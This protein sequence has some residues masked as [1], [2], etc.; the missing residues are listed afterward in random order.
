MTE[1]FTTVILDFIGDTFPSTISIGLEGFSGFIGK[2]G[3]PTNRIIVMNL[4]AVTATVNPQ[5]IVSR[6]LV[7]KNETTACWDL[8]SMRNM[9]LK[10]YIDNEQ[11]PLMMPI[12]NEVNVNFKIVHLAV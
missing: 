11:N 5:G 2:N 1:S 4:C 3:V 10:L 12:V 9:T 6:D 7:Y 8:G